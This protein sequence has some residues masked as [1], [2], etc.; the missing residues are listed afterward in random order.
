[1]KDASRIVITGFMASGKTSVARALAGMLECSM[2]DLDEF[3]SERERRSIRSIIEQKGERLFRQ[4]ESSALAHVLRSER[5]GVIALG[6]GAWT[7]ERN[8][9]L[10]ARRHCLTVWL[11]APFESCWQRITQAGNNERP[12][13]RDYDQ[14]RR[15]YQERLPS[16]RLATVRIGANGHKT[17]KDLAGEIVSRCHRNHSSPILQAAGGLRI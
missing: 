17:P 10:I 12:F 9:R 3:I 5:A 14:G 15:L 7:I 1:M 6:G 11:D 13:A 4:R 16:Y 8:R 2:I